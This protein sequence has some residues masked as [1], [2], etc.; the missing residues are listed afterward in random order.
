MLKKF[1]K[2]TAL[3]PY[4]DLAI[5]ILRVGI[6]FLMITHGWAKLERAMSGN[7]AF[8]DPLGIGSE[9]SLILT[10][11]SELVCSVLL[12]LGF[13]TRPALVSLIFTMLVI[14]FIVKAGEGLKKVEVALMYLIPYI[15][16]FIWGPGRYSLDYYI[17]GRK[18]GSER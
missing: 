17:F 12:I 8:A 11:F 15:S 9:L 2:V 1:F 3:P 10:I 6:S 7:W 4:V 18:R 16:L 5:F 13:L 14:V